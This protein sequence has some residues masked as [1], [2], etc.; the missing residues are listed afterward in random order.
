MLEK[1]N[2]TAEEG[3]ELQTEHEDV[4]VNHTIKITFRVTPEE[5]E[6]IDLKREISQEKTISAYV[7]RAAVFGKFFVVDKSQFTNLNK[8]LSGIR[9]SLNQMMKRINSTDRVY[10]EDFKKIA[11]MNQHLDDISKAILTMKVEI[12]L[13]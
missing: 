5:Y 6:C 1:Q 4:V 3:A 7:R 13:K 8:T 10:A 2:L 9:G 11:E 12:G